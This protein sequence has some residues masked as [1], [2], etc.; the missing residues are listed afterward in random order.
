MSEAKRVYEVAKATPLV[1]ATEGKLVDEPSGPICGPRNLR[2]SKRSGVCGIGRDESHV[3]F[4]VTSRWQRRRVIDV[5]Q[6]GNAMP[7][8]PL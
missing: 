7:Q 6:Y 5:R 1:V 3:V 4:V 2:R 8:L